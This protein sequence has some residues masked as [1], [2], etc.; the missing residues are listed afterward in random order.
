MFC[1]ILQRQN[2]RRNT[3]FGVDF[4]EQVE[5]SRSAI[6]SIVTKCL[7]EIEKRGIM[8]KVSL[9]KNCTTHGLIIEYLYSTWNKK[10]NFRQHFLV[11]FG[12]FCFDNFIYLFW[13]LIYYLMNVLIDEVSLSGFRLEIE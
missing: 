8:I 13:C 11:L 10:R 7:T 5:K 6:P 12:C 1:L 2:K 3:T 4:Q 9:Q